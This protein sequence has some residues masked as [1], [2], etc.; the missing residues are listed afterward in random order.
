[1][2]TGVLVFLVAIEAEQGPIAIAAA[3]PA[4]LAVF[5]LLWRL[6]ALRLG[7]CRTGRR[8]QAGWPELPA[9]SRVR[10]GAANSRARDDGIGGPS[11]SRGTG[12]QIAD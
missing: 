8:A 12:P 4:L 5:G 3:S 7:H 10:L 6:L 2:A 1:L 9:R 11:H